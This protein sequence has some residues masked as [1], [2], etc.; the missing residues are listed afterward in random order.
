M[1]R[2]GAGDLAARV[3]HGDLQ[4]G[5][6]AAVAGRPHDRGDARCPQVELVDGDRPA[7]RRSAA[8]RAPAP[9]RRG[10]C[11]RCAVDPAR[12][13]RRRRASARRS[14]WRRGRRR[15][16]AGAPSSADQPAGQLDPARLQRGQVERA[17]VRPADELQGRFVAGGD[18]DPASRRSCGR[19]HRCA[20]ATR[21][22]PCPG[23]GVAH[24]CGCRPPARRRGRR[25]AARRRAA[26][27]SPRHRRPARHPAASRRGRGRSSGR[28]A[29]GRW[30]APL[31]IDGTAGR[32]HQ[33]V[34][35]TTLRGPPRAGGRR[36]GEPSPSRRTLSTA[37]SVVHRCVERPGVVAEVAGE[38]GG[39]HEPVRIRARV[40]PS[41]AGRSSSSASAGGASPTSRCA[42]A[43]PMRPRSSTTWSRRAR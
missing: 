20:R 19:A 8:A 1:S 13:T 29:R 14:R 16:A 41:R 36:D 4:P 11:C 26:R 18:G 40:R 42:S 32:S 37:A 7:W 38:L 30:P 9:R 43:R 3:E 34:A 15:S 22:C 23:S 24:G 21:R 2:R 27:R 33:P 6:D 35:I 5:Y 12:A 39:G 17:M 10:R 31:A 28:S 25:R